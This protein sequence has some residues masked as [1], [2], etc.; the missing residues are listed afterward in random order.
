MARQMYIEN[1]GS[2]LVYFLRT[3]HAGGCC[4]LTLN[5]IHSLQSS[6]RKLYILLG[7]MHGIVSG[8]MI[9]GMYTLTTDDLTCNN[10]YSRI[11]HCM[12]CK[13]LKECVAQIHIQLHIVM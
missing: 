13:S 10:N 2:L 12:L 5:I 7:E 4:W 8:T 11:I 9:D 6:V 3:T 1:I